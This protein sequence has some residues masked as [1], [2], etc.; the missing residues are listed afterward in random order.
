[1]SKIPRI[2]CRELEIRGSGSS[3]DYHISIH[4]WLS[5]F[6]TVVFGRAGNRSVRPAL[7][8][9]PK[10]PSGR[11]HRPGRAPRP[12][13]S[14][15]PCR[16]LAGRLPGRRADRRAGVSLRSNGVWRPPTA[17]SHVAEGGDGLAGVHF[18]P[19]YFSYRLSRSFVTNWAY[20]AGSLEPLQCQTNCCSVGSR[21]IADESHSGE[22]AI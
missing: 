18:T 4:G 17:T 14:P 13:L 5:R 16:V 8:T 22:A 10:G 12:H 15:N 21:Q 19:R 2:E 20:A 3:V 7:S 6:V 9:T 11:K 1:M